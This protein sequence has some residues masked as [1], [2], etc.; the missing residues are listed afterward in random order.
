M[1]HHHAMLHKIFKI[2]AMQCP[3]VKLPVT[4][5]SFL[6]RT[7]VIKLDFKHIPTISPPEKLHMRSAKLAIHLYSVRPITD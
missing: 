5:N 1:S 7:I 2:I 6:Q 4:D 3:S